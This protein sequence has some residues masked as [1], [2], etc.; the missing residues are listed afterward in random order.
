M[1]KSRATTASSRS[2][3]SRGSAVTEMETSSPSLPSRAGERSSGKSG[4]TLIRI[5]QHPPMSAD[6]QKTL[7]QSPLGLYRPAFL[8]HG[9]L[10]WKQDPS[11]HLSTWLETAF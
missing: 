8:S 3:R 10:F 5:L 2:S 9:F 1:G 4:E 6:T 7:D 11:I